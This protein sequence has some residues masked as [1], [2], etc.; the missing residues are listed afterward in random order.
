MNENEH[1]TLTVCGE[2]NYNDKTHELDPVDK[3]I[4][5]FGMADKY[6]KHPQWAMFAD[7]IEEAPEPKYTLRERIGFAFSRIK[8]K[9]RKLF[10]KPIEHDEDMFWDEYDDWCYD[11]EDCSDNE[12]HNTEEEKNVETSMESLVKAVVGNNVKR[13]MLKDGSEL[14]YACGTSYCCLL[15]FNIN[16]IKAQV[17]DF[18]EQDDIDPENAEDYGC[19]NM[20]FIPNTEP[21]EDILSKYLISKDEYQ[22]ICK[23]LDCLSFGCCGWCI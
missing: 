23:E 6:K 11:D 3:I 17:R 5:P 1:I 16:G 22:Q 19:G 2:E 18:G 15:I 20:Q 13:M 12:Q 8:A 10:R 14:E 21:T 7:H 4:V 9:I